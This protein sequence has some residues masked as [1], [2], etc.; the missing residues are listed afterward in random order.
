MTRSPPPRGRPGKT[1][2]IFWS[3]MTNRF[4]AARNYR[5]DKAGTVTIMGAKFDVT[6]DIAHLILEYGITFKLVPPR[7][8]A[9]R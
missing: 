9:R 7:R 3:E 1:I 4:Y 8:R 2:R 5:I 6:D